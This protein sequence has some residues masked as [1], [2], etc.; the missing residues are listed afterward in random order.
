MKNVPVIVQSGTPQND[1]DHLF[2]MGQFI[3]HLDLLEKD[4]NDSLGQDVDIKLS[5]EVIHSHNTTFDTFHASIYQ[6]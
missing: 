5:W 1:N 4:R 3:R 2:E 6:L